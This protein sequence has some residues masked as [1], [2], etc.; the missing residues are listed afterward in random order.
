[1][2]PASRAP[3]ARSIFAALPGAWSLRRDIEDAR[4]GAGSFTGT[5]VFAPQSGE[6][7]LY[8]EQGELKLGAWRGPAWRRWIYALEGE[9]LAIRYPGRYPDSRAAL[10]CFVFGREP[11]GEAGAHHIHARHIHCCGE[12]RYDARLELRS[13][14]SLFLGYRVTGPAKDYRLT[15][16][17]TR[18]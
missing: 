17:L 16:I 11:N 14:G 4:F 12:D 10:H 2:H 13:D 3:L 6:T 15:T 8:E 9:A 1:M 7:L 5:A 18:A